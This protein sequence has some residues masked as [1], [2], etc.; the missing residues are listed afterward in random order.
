MFDL[1]SSKLLVLAVIA[2]IVV[3][4]KDM[5]VLLRTMGR[6]VGMI[7]RQAGEFRSQ[8]EEAMRDSE[9][10]EIRKEVETLG[11]ETSQTLREATSS[12]ENQLDE[13]GREVDKTTASQ[14][15]IDDPAHD[16]GADLTDDPGAV[17]PTSAVHAK[18]PEPAV[19][20]APVAPVAAVP[21]P[22]Q[23][24]DAHAETVTS[25]TGH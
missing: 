3:G 7:R 25:P 18:A 8:F 12:I 21:P 6:Y 15:P 23:T 1:S 13:V 5:I 17:E 22:R 20:P 14:P 19:T 16:F 2:L 11:E 4:P 9:L 24:A 10:A